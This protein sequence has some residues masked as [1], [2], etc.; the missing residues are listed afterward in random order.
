MYKILII[1][2]DRVMP[3]LFYFVEHLKNLGLGYAI[4]T[5][6]VTP[7]AERYAVEYG[8]DILHGPP[9]RK[10][11]S[12]M[13]NDLYQLIVRVRRKRFRHA[14]LYSDYHI[15]ASLA[16]F[17]ILKLKGMPIILW[18]RGELYDWD[19]FRWWQ[20][21]YFRI[22][23]PN[24]RMVILK[25]AYMKGTLKKAGFRIDEHFMELHNTVPLPEVTRS[26]FKAKKINL[27]FLNMF[28]PWRNVTFCIDVATGLRRAGVD[29]S[30][31]IVGEKNDA[32]ELVEQAR[33]LHAAIRAH[34]MENFVSVHPF[35]CNPQNQYLEGDIF[36]LPADL[37]YCNYALIE[38]MA[39]GLVPVVSN[40]DKDYLRIIEEEVSGYGR[41]LDAAQWVDVILKLANDRN[42][43]RQISANARRRIEMFY[44]TEHMFTKY[45]SAIGITTNT[46]HIEVAN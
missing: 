43:A 6:D 23:I 28:K 13:I 31:K 21:L 19:K 29:F 39:Y 26:A 5:H 32:R 40:A 27:L 30:M 15:I 14:E 9:H 20:R 44:S 12:R 10:S 22:V 41:P 35:S 4:Y 46:K 36:L 33:K 2:A 38:A 16:Y 45:C 25:E 3:K 34:G 24:V 17:F 1:G 18:C 8:V 37:I 7:D 11:I 42:Y